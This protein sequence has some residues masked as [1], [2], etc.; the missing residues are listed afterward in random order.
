M[1]KKKPKPDQ[2]KIHCI[3]CKH[4]WLIVSDKEI[5]VQ[6]CRNWA[7]EAIREH[8]EICPYQKGKK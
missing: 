2:Y 7:S 3:H 4:I 8:K 5:P 6:M 1:F